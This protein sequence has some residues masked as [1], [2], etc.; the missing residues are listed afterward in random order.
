MANLLPQAEI[1]AVN[2]DVFEFTED[3]SLTY[4]LDIDTSKIHDKNDRLDAMVQAIYL[5]VNT[6]VDK[7]LIYSMEGRYGWDY[8]DLIGMPPTYCVPEIERRLKEALLLD[9]RITDVGNFE[10]EV[11]KTEIHVTFSVVTIFGN[12]TIQTNVSI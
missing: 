6:Q 4:A 9:T 7:Y 12:A 8:E 5:L 11:E 3:T 10:F 2:L 1:D